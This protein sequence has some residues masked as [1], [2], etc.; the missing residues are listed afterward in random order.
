MPSAV[1]QCTQDILAKLKQSKGDL[2]PAEVKPYAR[3]LLRKRA[4]DYVI[5]RTENLVIVY[6][7]DK[8]LIPG[9]LQ[10][11][12]NCRGIAHE[13]IRSYIVWVHEEAHPPSAELRRYLTKK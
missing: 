12:A 11:L 8:S 3:D 1:V 5:V 6:F 7:F 10:E 13:Q 2:S 9:V 4:Y